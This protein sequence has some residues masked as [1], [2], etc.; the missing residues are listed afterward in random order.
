MLAVLLVAGCGTKPVDYQ[1]VLST[2]AKAAPTTSTD[3]PVPISEYLEKAGVQGEPMTPKTL[4]ELTVTLPQPPGWTIVQDDT[5]QAAYEVIRK[6]GPGAY[7]PTAMLMV[8][9]LTG[10]FDIA[11]AI[12][13]GYA[14]AQLSTGFK[15]LNASMK[16]FKGFPS[17]M[18]EGSY[19]VGDS[20]LHTYNR[21]IIVTA[22]P[23]ANQRYLIQFSVTTAADEAQPQG[24]DIEKVIGGFSVAVK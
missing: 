5:T 10:N 3:K 15:Q 18:I 4:T 1:S 20:R 14:D 17:A 2:S 11:E 9:K 8:F 12:K 7:P 22:K 6:T 24:Q 16:D 19:T 13:H 23:P 21:I